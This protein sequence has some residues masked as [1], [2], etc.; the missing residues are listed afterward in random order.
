MK[1]NNLILILKD[2]TS[3]KIHEG[4]RQITLTALSKFSG[5]CPVNKGSMNL[6]ILLGCVIMTED[7]KIRDSD[8]YADGAGGMLMMTMTMMI[9]SSTGGTCP[10][11]VGGDGEAKGER[12][13]RRREGRRRRRRD[14]HRRRD[15]RRSRKD[16]E[17][18]PDH[19][20]RRHGL[21]HLR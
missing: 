13:G 17:R 15:R 9:P 8:L 11:A 4:Q 18:Q 21:P 3:Q 7:N 5:N 14:L 6:I 2:F 10:D 16:D 19:D 1:L 12:G 20:S